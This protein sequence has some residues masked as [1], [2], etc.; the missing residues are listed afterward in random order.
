MP[1]VWLA[2]SLILFVISLLSFVWRTGASNDPASPVPLSP[3]GALA[4]RIVITCVLAVAVIYFAL[5]VKTLRRYAGKSI[6]PPK[7]GN[8]FGMTGEGD[9]VGGNPGLERGKDIGNREKLTEK[10]KPFERRD[11]ER[12]RERGTDAD[13]AMEEDAT[14]SSRLLELTRIGTNDSGTMGAVVGEKGGGEVHG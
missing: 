1:A 6:P 7:M 8:R 10:S 3:H 2:W 12:R 13:G 4:P 5:I 9:I 14:Q 11:L